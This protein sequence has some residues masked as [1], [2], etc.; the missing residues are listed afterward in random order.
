M[1]LV[2]DLQFTKFVSNN[3]NQ[4]LLIY[5]YLIEG[6]KSQFPYHY[7]LLSKSVKL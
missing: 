5:D 4:Y 7:D 2:F 3:N 1:P 6:L